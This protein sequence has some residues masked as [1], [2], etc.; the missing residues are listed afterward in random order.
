MR[1]THQVF[2]RMA[3]ALT[4]RGLTRLGDYS[5]PVAGPRPTF[6]RR[7]FGAPTS[8]PTVGAMPPPLDEALRLRRRVVIHYGDA[9]GQTTERVVQ[10]VAANGD[11]LIA[12]CDLR[13]EQRT[14]RL[15]RIIAARWP[16]GG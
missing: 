6:G 13:G 12:H 14:F 2:E 10:P 8:R 7:R 5:G 1:T 15:D 4:E 16:D 3:A 9:K 11:Y